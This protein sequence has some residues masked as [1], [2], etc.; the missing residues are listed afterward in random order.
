MFLRAHPQKKIDNGKVAVK[1]GFGKHA[2]AQKGY[3]ALVAHYSF[4]AL[5]CNPAEGHEKGLV[6]GLITL[7]GTPP[8]IS[9]VRTNA[10]RKLSSF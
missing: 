4:S 10:S 6:E 8:R 2:Q 1:D 5:F 7:W 3:T 9:K